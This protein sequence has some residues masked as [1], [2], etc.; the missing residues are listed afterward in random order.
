MLFLIAGIVLVGE[1]VAA[2]AEFS[3]AI[4]YVDWYGVGKSALEGL[5]GVKKV[6]SGFK[7]FRE[8]NTV[9]YDPG[10]INVEDMIAAL[11]AAGTYRGLADNW[12]RQMRFPFFDFFF[13][14]LKKPIHSNVKHWIFI[15]IR[16]W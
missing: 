7:D 9:T 3:E 1:V 15:Y 11:K 12:N 4:F 6:T 8:I 10:V 5:D 16:N 14:S 13:D 2:D